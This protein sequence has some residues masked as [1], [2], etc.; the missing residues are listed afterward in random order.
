MS[1]MRTDQAMRTALF[2]C[3]PRP[4]TVTGFRTKS[5]DN[6]PQRLIHVHLTDQVSLFNHQICRPRF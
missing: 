2:F 4:G 5:Q 6:R 3:H 1:D